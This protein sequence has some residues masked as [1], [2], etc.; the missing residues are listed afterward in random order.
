MI[1]KQGGNIIYNFSQVSVTANSYG[2]YTGELDN[3]Q[4]GV[5]HVLIKGPT[6]LT[7]KFANI[8]LKPGNNSKDWSAVALLTG[9]A[10][11]DDKVNIQDF[12]ILVEDYQKTESPAD[13]NFDGKVN[14]QD[15]RF[16]VE[17]YR[18]T[19]EE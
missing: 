18:K 2:I 19:G 11:N 6:H 9:D 14:I 13:F 10:N 12:R 17:N 7:K 5:Y 1:F 3:L 15:F 16:I 4:S 8:E